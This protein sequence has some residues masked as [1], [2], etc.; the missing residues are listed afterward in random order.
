MTDWERA[1][2]LLT[3]E[4]TCVLVKGDSTLVS[5]KRGIAPMIDWLGEGQRLAG[6][7]AADRIV[8]K[9]AAMLFVKAGLSA[10]YAEVLSEP[11]KAYLEKRGIPVTYGVLTPAIINRAGDGPCPMEAAVAGIDD[12]EE[13]LLA[14]SAK[15]AALRGKKSS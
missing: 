9:A 6:F 2:T 1:K 8:G 11:G 15:L 7:A 3:G 5:T 13:G 12:P 4:I 14:L 10:V